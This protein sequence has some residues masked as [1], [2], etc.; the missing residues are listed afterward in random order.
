MGADSNL[1]SMKRMSGKK[2]A[3]MTVFFFPSSVEGGGIGKVA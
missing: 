3:G 1:P 2:G